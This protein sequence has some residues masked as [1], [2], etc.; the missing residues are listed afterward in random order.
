MT[1]KYFIF[2]RVELWMKSVFERAAR[3]TITFDEMQSKWTFSNRSNKITNKE[4]ITLTK[5]NSNADWNEKKARPL[6]LGYRRKHLKS[7]PGKCPGFECLW[8]IPR[9]KVNVCVCAIADLEKVMKFL[10]QKLLCWAMQ[11]M[12]GLRFTNLY[13]HSFFSSGRIFLPE[14]YDF[15]HHLIQHQ[16]ENL[17]R[18]L[19]S[20]FESNF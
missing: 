6:Y 2:A 15:C 7:W 5:T 16:I 13:G 14:A 4:N 18:L 11:R 20:Y 1:C 3:E 10:L 12:P 17:K 9:K 19:F 8:L